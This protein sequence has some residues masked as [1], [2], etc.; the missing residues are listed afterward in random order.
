MDLSLL[1]AFLGGTLALLSPCSV[2]VLPAFFAYAF[3]SP[4]ELFSRTGAFFLGLATAL[5]PLG[6]LAG[7]LGAWV[8]ANRSGIMMW[9]LIAVIALG[10]VMLLGIPLP[11]LTRQ[12]S[13]K[14]TSIA[15][16]Y[17]LGAVYG[18]AGGCA[19]PIFGAVLAMAAFGGNALMGGFTMLLYAAGMTVP[20]LLLALLWNRIP[21]VR[22]LMRPRELV[23]G[24]WRNAWSN[25]IGG[26]ITIAVGV[27]M[28]VTDGAQKFGGVLDASTQ[29]AVEAN[30]MRATSGTSNLIVLGIGAL[31][32][33]GGWA[34]VRW[35]R[36]QH[37]TDAA[38]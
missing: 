37:A 2:M 22:K 12:Q 13:A 4:R 11:A 29:A 17:A 7:T 36:R 19:G 3:H 32:A 23:I 35:R 38:R 21:G 5:V 6:L 1:G 34:I 27:F 28:L 14:G 8:A 24:R 30:V 31:L 20:L 16:V 33:L 15:S 9:V 18:L 10:V 25:V 26:L